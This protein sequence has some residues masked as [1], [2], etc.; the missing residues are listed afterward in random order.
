[1][2]PQ[3][4]RPWA[5]RGDSQ[6]DLPLPG[7]AMAAALIALAA[8][9]FLI[10]NRATSGANPAPAPGFRLLVDCDISGSMGAEEKRA[11]L[12]AVEATFS[13]V[14]PPDSQ[15][16]FWAFGQE[17]WELYQGKPLVVR[18][19]WP[20]LDRIQRSRTSRPGTSPAEVLSRNLEAAKQAGERGEGVAIMLLWDGEDTDPAAT[21]RAV[22]ELAEPAPPGGGLGRRPAG[23][24]RLRRRRPGPGAASVRGARRPADLQRPVRHPGRSGPVP[25]AA[26][27]PAAP[28]NRKRQ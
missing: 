18:E 2:R 22:K 20:L 17:A 23:G 3:P 12:G 11:N 26:S 24:P 16:T 21:R 9:G 10:W 6:A 8:V 7:W 27:K 14:L 19:L 15:L 4:N 28:S 1:M 13:R 5:T 25:R